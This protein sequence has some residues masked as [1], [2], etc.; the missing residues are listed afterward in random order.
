LTTH[1]DWR[2]KVVLIQ[3][4]LPTATV[5]AERKLVHDHF[6]M[7]IDAIRLTHGNDVIEVIERGDVTF[8]EIVA[9]YNA[10]QVAVVSTFWDG[11][12][13]AP[14]E[15]TASQN[16][17][18]PGALVLSEFMG[19]SRSLSGAIRVNPWAIEGVA[20][21]MHQA[22]SMSL[23]ERRANH[24]R[25]HHYVMSQTM[26]RWA[27]GFLE[28]LDK[29]SKLAADLVFAPVIISYDT[30]TFHHGYSWGYWMGYQ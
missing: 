18:D 3:V 15:F 19:C 6:M 22:L 14:Y 5:K 4:I 28:H 13:L 23:D 11:L 26:E 21:A 10:A 8:T 1:R 12:N 24:Q 30:H 2:D 29:A 9:Y 16:P 25:R 20:E 7:E 17:E 27:L